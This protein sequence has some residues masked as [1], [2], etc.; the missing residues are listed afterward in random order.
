MAKKLLYLF[1]AL[2]L[3]KNNSY[4]QIFG[5]SSEIGIMAGP[6]FF[7]SDYG[8]RFDTKTNF[9]N[10]GFGIGI[11]HVTNFSYN[12]RAGEPNRRTFFNDHFKLKTEISF[13]KSEFRHYG[14]WVDTPTNNVLG[15]QQLRAMRG[16][17][18]V[19]NFGTQMEYYPWSVY[20]SDLK[21]AR[22]N[23]A[24]YI[25]LGGQYN[26]YTTKSYS[27]LGIVDS[28]GVTPPKYQGASRSETNATFSVTS[29]VGARY[30]IGDFDDIILDLRWQHYFSNWVDGLNPDSRLYPENRA[31]DWQFWLT[32]GYVY[33]FE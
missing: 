29:S 18:S 7:Q 20:N 6:I 22:Y 2:F 27:M 26:I 14:K 17:T 28:P 25:S 12:S 33:R 30:K 8:Q 21:I 4:S 15:Q 3:F 24:P 13:N 10:N 16:N 19:T 1:I 11:F 23:F 5:N 31:N 32:V 9:G